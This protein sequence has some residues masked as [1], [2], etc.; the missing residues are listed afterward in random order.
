MAS[1]LPAQVIRANTLLFL[2]LCDVAMFPALAALGCLDATA[3]LLGISLII[4]NLL[5]NVIGARIFQPGY[6]QA[7]RGVAYV[8]IA[9][10]A[11]A[12]LPIWG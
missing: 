9:A 4:P 5:G 7:Y 2:L 11:V 10:S 8:I 6:E 3:V 12:G 1:A